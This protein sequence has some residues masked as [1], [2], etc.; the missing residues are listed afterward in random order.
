MIPVNPVFGVRKNTRAKG[1]SVR[2]SEPAPNARGKNH[3]MDGKVPKIL[4][5]GKGFFQELDL[6]GLACHDLECKH[7]Q[8]KD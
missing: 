7:C 4:G 2:P 6:T 5:I 3:G 8:S 1:Q